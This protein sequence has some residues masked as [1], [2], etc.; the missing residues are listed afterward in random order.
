MGSV[1]WRP[2]AL[3][4]LAELDSTIGE[5]IVAKTI[6]LGR[7]IGTLALEPLHHGLH[8]LYKLRV[9]DYRI[10]YS[11]SKSVVIVEMVGHRSAVYH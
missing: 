7:N 6:W 3:E 2:L 9:G 8:G 11:L 4:A 10:I 5:R 1:E